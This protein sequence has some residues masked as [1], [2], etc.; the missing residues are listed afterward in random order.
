MKIEVEVKD[1]LVAKLGEEVIKAYLTR[2]VA[3]IEKSLLENN[4]NGLK[5]EDEEELIQKAWNNFNKRG[6][7]C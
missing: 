3:H 2:K 4:S 6:M 7:S 5:E 1:E